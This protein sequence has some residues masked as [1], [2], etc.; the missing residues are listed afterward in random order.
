MA[1][2]TDGAIETTLNPAAQRGK[3]KSVLLDRKAIIRQPVAKPWVDSDRKVNPEREE[4]HEKARFSVLVLFATSWGVAE[5]GWRIR[6]RMSII[7][8]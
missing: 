1:S 7:R 8:V 4:F 5:V 3:K 6:E 2:R